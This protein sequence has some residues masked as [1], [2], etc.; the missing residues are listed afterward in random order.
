MPVADM[1]RQIDRELHDLCQPLTRLS[2]HLELGQMM[3]S[4]ETLRAAVEC[5]MV[6]CREVCAAVGRMRQRL[7]EMQLRGGAL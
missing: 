4:A 5:S 3:D 7:A 6:E 1:V 2:C